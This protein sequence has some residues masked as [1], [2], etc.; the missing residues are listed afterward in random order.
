MSM[1]LPKTPF[2]Y[3]AAPTAEYAISGQRANDATRP[4]TRIPAPDT[5]VPLTE[6]ESFAHW[7]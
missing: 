3:F 4:E 1:D 5:E 6:S 2:P 7:I